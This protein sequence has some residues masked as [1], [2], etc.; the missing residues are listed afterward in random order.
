MRQLTDDVE[1]DIYEM[2][3]FFEDSLN[4]NA[5]SIRVEKIGN[6]PAKTYKLLKA[7]RCAIAQCSP[8][9]IAGIIIKH[10]KMIDIYYYDGE[11]PNQHERI[12]EAFGVWTG[13]NVSS[14]SAT[15]TEKKRHSSVFYRKPHFEIDREAGKASM[16]IPEQ[17]IREEDF[18][19]AVSACVRCK[20]KTILVPLS[21]YRAFGAIVS[22]P[23]RIEVDS[24][25]EAFS[26]EIKSNNKKIFE[27]PQKSFR[28]FDADFDE[29]DKLHKG[30][31]Y[32]LVKSGVS[33]SGNLESV[34]KN[35]SYP[36]WDEYSFAEVTDGTV[37][38]LD[39]RKMCVTGHFDDAPL[40][41]FVSN[42]Y[43]LI[44]EGKQ[45]QTAYHHPTVSFMISRAMIKGSF[46]WCNK[47]RFN[48]VRQANSIIELPDDPN[49]YGV[50]ILLDDL[51]DPVE[52]Q[53]LI[54]L[55]EPGKTPKLLC[56]YVLIT[57][58]RCYPERRRFIF[59]QTASVFVSGDYMLT[60]INCSWLTPEEC[61]VDLTD[62]NESADFKLM[63]AGTEYDLSVPL[64]IFK[65]GFEKE[66]RVQRPDYL[67]HTEL[68]NDLYVNVPGAS[69]ALVYKGKNEKELIPGENISDGV[70]RFDISSITQ[71]IRASSCTFSSIK[72]KFYDNKWRNICLYRVQKRLWINKKDIVFNDGIVCV[73]ADCRGNSQLSVRF[74]KNDTK[75]IV[76]EKTLVNG[77]NPFPELDFDGLYDIEYFENEVDPFGFTI[78]QTPVG[79]PQ[80]KVGAVDLDDISNC[81]I[82]PYRI[83]NKSQD[84]SLDYSYTAFITSRE[85][86]SKYFGTLTERKI[87]T[88]GGP[89]YIMRTL[90]DNLRIRLYREESDLEIL[91]LKTKD[92]DEY[93]DLYYDR[94]GKKL[95]SWGDEVLDRSTDRHRF[96]P[97]YGDTTEF[98]I[99]IRRVK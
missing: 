60:P 29:T 16:V 53:Y 80:H 78:K 62:G 63:L 18:A 59:Q 12:A 6:K 92:W 8:S 77:L 66:W 55:D 47:Q 43:T 1:D 4:E 3:D 88:P 90:S 48:I 31:N 36:A 67:W 33:I 93:G 73:D 81:K 83:R 86:E 39:G 70:F 99:K 74:A 19:G 68:K 42:E 79:R 40:F 71:S 35:T 52:G 87:S 75:E 38:Y 30:Q 76:V 61:I 32:L 24:I 69:A 91:S 85:S 57:D 37:L 46:V 17:K 7:T 95:I 22:E 56:R 98:F 25:F 49:D 97:L 34:Y 41:E 11:I 65:Y 58:L 14:F 82:V 51:L 84:L 54:W 26:I 96:V 50:T 94:Q 44:F 23:T 9:I 21:L 10:L 2:I 89:K 13:E 64:L 28:I 5:D 72:L 15:K 20:D 45:I 27:I